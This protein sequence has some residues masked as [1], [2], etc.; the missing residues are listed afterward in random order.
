VASDQRLNKEVKLVYFPQCSERPGKS[1][2]SEQHEIATLL[3]F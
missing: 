2:A 3:L 1:R